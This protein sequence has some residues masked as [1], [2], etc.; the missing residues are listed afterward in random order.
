MSLRSIKFGVEGEGS[1]SYS[2]KTRRFILTKTSSIL[3]ASLLLSSILLLIIS[4]YILLQNK[5]AYAMGPT[6]GSCTN[7]Y[8]YTLKSM[9]ASNGL[10]TFDLLANQGKGFIFNANNIQGYNVT[11]TIHPANQSKSGNTQSGSIWY[12]TTSL[13]FGNGV[14]VTGIEPNQDKTVIVKGIIESQMEN[15]PT[16]GNGN[17]NSLESVEW[18]FNN[19]FGQKI[20]YEVNWYTISNY[21]TADTGTSQV[22]I[23]TL[24]FN[25]TNFNN[26]EVKGILVDLVSNGKVVAVGFTPATFTLQNGKEYEIEMPDSYGNKY[27]FRNWADG[28]FGTLRPI[29][30]AESGNI[31]L[32]VYYIEKQPGDGIS[33]PSTTLLSSVSTQSLNIRS[34]PSMPATTT[35]VSNP[36]NH[37]NSLSSSNSSQGSESNYTTITIPAIQRYPDL[38]AQ[39]MNA[40]R[41]NGLT[42]SNAL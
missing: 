36:T 16:I 32:I 25:N 41:L 14:C 34:L 7:E 28:E 15:N 12:E 29:K 23:D 2:E 42:D 3:S 10:H 6:P 37:S 9:V 30:V 4:P 5:P 11:F 22:K 18:V 33:S 1:S 13:G 38:M 31:G 17:P 27:H 8:D 24:D 26:N 20:P 19:P 39:V 40:L 35:V 21:P